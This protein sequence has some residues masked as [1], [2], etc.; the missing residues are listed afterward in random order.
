MRA[1]VLYEPFTPFKVEELSIIEPRAG[2]V[3]G[4]DLIELG[5][6]ESVLDRLRSGSLAPATGNQ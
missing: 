2:E 6:G 4:D 5:A 3:R 1:A